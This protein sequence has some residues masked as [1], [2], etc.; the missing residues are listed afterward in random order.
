[1][2]F[3]SVRQKIEFFDEKLDNRLKTIIY[4]I[5]GYSV[6]H[7]RK[8]FIIT[9]VHRQREETIKIY[10]SRGIFDKIPTSVHE[11]WRGVDGR[12][13]IYTT[14]ELRQ[15]CKFINHSFEYT[16]KHKS[17]IVHKIGDGAFHFHI[18][19]DSDGETILKI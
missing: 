17:A 13:S 16:G 3:K 5:D 11:Y 15:L 2:E 19:T 14:K 10:N 4:A 9:D 18:Q 1:M 8:S 12:A 6:Y 7:F